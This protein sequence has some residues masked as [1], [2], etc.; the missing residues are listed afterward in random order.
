MVLVYKYDR[1]NLLITLLE[2]RHHEYSTIASPQNQARMIT[3]AVY[4]MV[5]DFFI[6]EEELELMLII[7]ILDY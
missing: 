2:H 6:R 5:S 4:H 7:D 3:R 1:L